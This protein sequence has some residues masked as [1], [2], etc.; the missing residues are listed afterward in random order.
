MSVGDILSII[1]GSG[2]SVGLVVL[3][4]FIAGYIVPK[5]QVDDA[6]AREEEW[7]QIAQNERA[8]ADAGVLAGQIVKDVLGSLSKRELK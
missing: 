2:G 6:K 7:K 1:G 4:L 5:S 3:A 8:R